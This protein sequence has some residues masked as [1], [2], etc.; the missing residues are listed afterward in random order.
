MTIG[1]PVYVSSGGA[2]GS[3]TSASFSPT[4]G[5]KLIVIALDY[6]NTDSGTNTLSISDSEGLTWT[7]QMSPD[8]HEDNGS[9]RWCNYQMYTADPGPS[10]PSMTVTVTTT[11]N[12][13]AYIIVEVPADA[14]LD[15]SNYGTGTD[16]AGDPSASVT[17]SPAAC[18][19]F[20]SGQGGNNMPTPSGYTNILQTG[21]FGGTWRVN[22]AYDLSTPST[23]VNYTSGNLLTTAIL[24]EIAEASGATNLTP[25][26]V[27]SGTG[28]GTPAISQSH[29]LTPTGIGSV[30]SVGT[31]SATE[32]VSADPA[33]I[34][35]AVSVAS[36][37]ITGTHELAAA[38]IA[39]STSVGTPSVTQSHEL[40][41]T[42][43]ASTPILG[44]PTVSIG[45]TNL[46]PVGVGSAPTVAAPS[47]HPGAIPVG[48]SSAGTVGTPTLSQTHAL[49]ANDSSI[50]T[51]VGIPY[52]ITAGGGGS[53]DQA[54]IR[55]RRR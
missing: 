2:V 36:P 30:T 6:S 1:T 7:A 53:G 34:S 17:G 18:I 13:A 21:I 24:A 55:R 52:L 48:I 43:V 41:P 32:G 40:V 39:S 5:N 27:G 16:T 45:T 19:A 47:I 12:Y 42:V 14:D 9:N 46:T 54:V 50:D 3:A 15:L 31:P 11:A 26:G 37:T 51:S 33:D 44:T 20:V 29:D 8:V 28:V 38:D 23:T 49:A 25:T 22:V 10:P 35:S 4:D